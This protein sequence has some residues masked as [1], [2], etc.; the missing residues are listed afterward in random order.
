[1]TL[2]KLKDITKG[3][4]TTTVADYCANTSFSLQSLAADPSNKEVGEWSSTDLAVPA[5]DK[6]ATTLNLSGL[7]KGTYKVKWV[8]G[9]T[10]CPDKSA[11]SLTLKVDAAPTVSGVTGS[12]PT[13][14]GGTGTYSASGVSSV[15]AFPHT[16]S[17]STSSASA[18]NPTRSF[19]GATNLP[20][21]EIRF[22]S[23]PAYLQAVDSATVILTVGSSCGS[24]IARRPLNYRLKPRAVLGSIS[25]P[26][27]VCSSQPASLAYGIAK[28]ANTDS[29]AW[30][31]DGISVS[32]TGSAL[33]DSATVPSAIWSGYAGDKTVDVVVALSN[34]CGAGA[35]SNPFRT[36]VVKAKALE[37]LLASRTDKE[38]SSPQGVQRVCL[39]T[40]N[41]VLKAGNN[42]LLAGA[43]Y[44]YYRNGAEE[45]TWGNADSAVV[46]TST[47]SDNDQLQ[48]TV[49][50]NS[51]CFTGNGTSPLSN[52]VTVDGYD[53]VKTTVVP[54]A[55]ESC[56]DSPISLSV[57]ASKGN[58]GYEWVNENNLTVQKGPSNTLVLDA[59]E[60][61]GA[62]RVLI[63][64]AVCPAATSKPLQVRLYQ[65]P[66]ANFAADPFVIIYTDGIK[67]PMPVTYSRFNGQA[68]SDSLTFVA[69]TE[70][71]SG[72]LGKQWITEK[73]KAFP[74]IIPEKVETEAD[75]ALEIGTGKPGGPGCRTLASLKV[76][77]TLPLKA[78][79]AFT[80]NGDGLNDTWKLVGILKY[81][82][83][84]VRVFNRWGAQV[85]QDLEG[86]KVPWDGTYNGSVL[87][88]GTYY[89]LLELS[90]SPD[91]TD[92]T[93]SGPLTIVY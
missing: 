78:P 45:T 61:S 56:E 83:V 86:Y 58:T 51:G 1:L 25:G 43:T 60:K 52:K 46:S 64:N 63:G 33:A 6:N 54:S 22:E 81:A 69:W 79:N 28:Q 5:A 44:R 67:V 38:G 71:I 14:E 85:F 84:S 90:G 87:P 29:Y 66:R 10:Q 32:G 70:S 8:V 24:S 19:V 26:P 40:Q 20:T 35:V 48:V 41:T 74:N 9:S 36:T 55:L 21:A 12:D 91:N 47:L 16:Y 65:K 93:I 57:P 76:F 53:T 27:Q 49:S 30:T 59:A 50:S 3:K 89:Y 23:S 11:D 17:W 13:C 77:N 37:A 39:K 34:S 68:L 82:K 75:Y 62:Y 92:Q 15:F 72:G 31:F 88:A 18:G 42:N 80:P 4:I 73:G 2:N 7:P